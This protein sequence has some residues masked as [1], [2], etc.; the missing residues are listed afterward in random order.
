M[1]D[2]T[3]SRHDPMTFTRALASGLAS[4]G[5]PGRSLPSPLCRLH[6]RMEPQ[7]KRW[8]SCPRWH[9]S[10]RAHDGRFL[11]G[12]VLMLSPRLKGWAMDLRISRALTPARII[13]LMVMALLIAGLVYLRL[14][15]GEETA[16]VPPG[17]RP[18]T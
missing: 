8:Q 11:A 15:A 6:D 14:S 2:R 10:I 5:Y 18:A 17:R 13:A 12:I 4:R 16:A 7:R 3:R 9:P 1:S